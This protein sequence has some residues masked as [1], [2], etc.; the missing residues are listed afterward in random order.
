M[1]M[2][3]LWHEMDTMQIQMNQIAYEC[4]I[5]EHK[6]TSPIQL[7]VHC[8]VL[9]GALPCADCLKL[10]INEQSLNGHIRAIH[11]ENKHT[12]SDC[13][14]EFPSEK[15]LY[16]HLVRVHY[17]K[18]C[19]LCDALVSFDECQNHMETLHKITNSTTIRLNIGLDHQKQF[20]CQLC[21]DNKSV[22]RLEK[23]FFHFLYFHKCSLQSLI[24]CIL[25]DNEIDS[26]RS[27]ENCDDD[28]LAKCSTCGSFYT[29]SIPKNFHNIYC[30]GFIHCAKCDHSFEDQDRFVQHLEK[31]V[32]KVPEIDFCDDCNAADKLDLH[33]KNVHNFSTAVIGSKVSN[34]MNSRN[35]CQ[36]CGRNL[37]SE[38]NDLSKLIEHFRIL[39]KFNVRAILSRLN[40]RQGGQ[41]LK[42]I[43]DCSSKR[44]AEGCSG[45]L[46]IVKH[47]ENADFQYSM[48]FDAKQVKCVYSSGSDYDSSESDNCITRP[49]SKS[50]QCDFCESRTKSK[51]VHVMH[52]HKRHGF[53]L[54][55]PEFRC[56][57]CQKNFKSNRSLKKHNE[58]IH[59]KRRG[60]EKRFK[61]SFC[62]FGC[63]GKGKMR[64]DPIDEYE[65]IVS[66]IL[67]ESSFYL[68]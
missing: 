35:H 51:F 6:F 45:I 19:Q 25:N 36:F 39:H 60:N 16:F 68:I 33:L 13:A 37:S 17:K 8:I 48:D 12:C 52:M 3:S 53:E 11:N 63:N 50:Y 9:H 67:I 62:T 29:W 2:T 28:T 1:T 27:T 30:L 15:D 4:R 47:D 14:N 31:C 55:T 42:V 21:Q 41:E 65:I 38:A 5:C 43:Q 40:K 46:T 54:K 58:N 24:Q 61:C 10:F 18:Q 57:V 20:H 56:N 34:L 32:K 44:S 23:L 7:T 26:L 49:P 66:S 64:Y 22:N 59:H